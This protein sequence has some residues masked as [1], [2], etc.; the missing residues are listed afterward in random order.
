MRKIDF[1][2]L[3]TNASL[4]AS[5]V[6]LKDYIVVEIH[7][8]HCDFAVVDLEVPMENYSVQ[9]SGVTIDYSTAES[10]LK[11]KFSL[12]EMIIMGKSYFHELS[13]TVEKLINT[14][15]FHSNVISSQISS[16]IQELSEQYQISLKT[17]THE[18]SE[19]TIQ[20]RSFGK[21]NLKTYV[22]NSNLIAIS[23]PLL[24]S[25]MF[26]HYFDMKR[27]LDLKEVYENLVISAEFQM[28]LDDSLREFS[29]QALKPYTSGS[30]SMSGIVCVPNFYNEIHLCYM[31]EM[32]VS[33]RT[34]TFPYTLEILD[35]AFFNTNLKKIRKF[36]GCLHHAMTKALKDP[37][38]VGF[39]N[40]VNPVG[41]GDNYQVLELY[42][43]EHVKNALLFILNYIHL[44]Y[45]FESC[46]CAIDETI[47]TLGKT[48]TKSVFIYKM[49]DLRLELTNLD[50]Y[51]YN[52]ILK[53]KSSASDLEVDLDIEPV[54]RR[55]SENE[56]LE[57]WK[58]VYV[59]YFNSVIKSFCKG[60]PELL[61][62]FCKLLM[63]PIGVL[64]LIIDLLEEE[65]HKRLNIEFVWQSLRV[66]NDSC[67]FNVKVWDI[68]NK[69]V[70][71]TFIIREGKD[72]RETHTNLDPNFAAL[73]NQK[74]SSP[75]EI[76]NCVCG[77]RLD[78]LKFRH[79]PD[80]V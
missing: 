2:C 32:M 64:G 59:S 46:K 13:A 47:K 16:V 19:V 35:L 43:P 18:T 69:S 40:T 48:I 77:K 68:L 28:I 33:I 30:Y 80:S 34:V 17:L 25:R 74:D 20:T 66:R 76:M 22:K 7:E 54:P 45:L 78:E 75:L 11:L 60:T 56:K 42:K 36:D 58:K 1:H 10:C 26:E 15:I 70:D 61:V 24:T 3:L 5:V 44:N 12:K 21:V 52:I 4:P 37:E 65:L 23:S 71:V 72:L 41:V 67:R 29:L 51:R 53:M 63:V 50:D 14:L 6:L 55:P 39:K 31:K 79:L 8:F 38:L 57:R 62:S 27:P 9:T 49:L 73:F